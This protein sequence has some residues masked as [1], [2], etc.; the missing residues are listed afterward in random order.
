MDKEQAQYMDFCTLVEAI[1]MREV[2]EV[3]KEFVE[4][5]ENAF[6]RVY[7]RN[8]FFEA[9]GFIHPKANFEMP[10]GTEFYYMVE[11]LLKNR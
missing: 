11:H 9:V 2:D 7:W 6:V 10:K 4:E 5:E 8:L 3:W 1:S